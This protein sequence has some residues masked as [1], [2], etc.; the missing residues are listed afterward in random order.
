MFNALVLNVRLVVGDRYLKVG[1]GSPVEK[2]YSYCISELK[3][4]GK[5]HLI[6]SKI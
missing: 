5:K 6:F 1:C 3:N 4:V 2:N